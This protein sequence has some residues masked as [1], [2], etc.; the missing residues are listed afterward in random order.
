M[1]LR[2]DFHIHSCLSPCGTLAMSPGA[3]ARAARAAGLNA[4]ALT[5]HN[6]ARNAPAL[7]EACR[8]YGL[9]ALHGVEATTSEELHVLCLFDHVETALDFGDMLMKRL[10]SIR[11]L[12]EKMGDQVVV[13][14]NENIIEQ[15]PV[16]L[17]S[18]TDITLT[19]LAES[20][21]AAGGLFVPSHI[22]RPSFSLLSQL[23]I[24]PDLP[25]DALEITTDRRR[26]GLTDVILRPY[27]L[28]CASDAHDLPDIGRNHIVIDCKRCD[29]SSVRRALPAARLHFARSSRYKNP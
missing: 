19:D 25:Y 17:G 29:V 14:A 22:D 12:P 28:I 16:F 23:G 2:A 6:C 8:Q 7:A 10:P 4:I 20:V 15:I 24:I 3:I 21:T 26:A 5:D 18:A 27:S 11:N 1:I 13:D 9:F